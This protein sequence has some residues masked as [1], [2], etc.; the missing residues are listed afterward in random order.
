MKALLCSEL[1]GLD[2]LRVEDVPSPVPGRDQVVIAV[3]AAGV[4]FPDTLIVAGKYQIKP[5]LPF[6][7]GGEFAGV[8][9]ELGAGVTSVKVGERVL[10]VSLYGGFAEATV[11]DANRVVSIAP[12]I[13]FDVAAALMFAH[14]TSWHALKDRG[15]LRPGETLLV[16]GAS[17]GVGLAAVEIGKLMGATVIAAASTDAKLAACRERGADHTINYAHD[18]LKDAVRAL[19]ADRGADVVYDPVGGDSSEPALRATAWNGRFLV[20]GFASGTI[21]RIPLNLPLLK[22]ISIVGVF[23]GEF[24]RREPEHNAENARDIM[25]AVADG[26]LKP[27]ISGRYPL[28]RAVDAL[29]AIERRE[30]T[31]KVIIEP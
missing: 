4:N 23:W 24:M 5:P 15:A 19:T 22:G 11:V 21:P 13:S 18:D 9:K 3:K 28:T 6:T 14:G 31:G 27:L 20:I 17:G 25:Q 12:S 1:T 26:K 2:A 16:L 29:R 10:G 30:V 8:V 7:P